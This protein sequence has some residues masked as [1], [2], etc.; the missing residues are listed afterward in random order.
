MALSECGSVS[1]ETTTV[2]QT[3]QIYP[4]PAQ[5]RITVTSEKNNPMSIAIVNMLGEVIIEKDNFES[6]TQIDI[7]HLPHSN[8]IIKIKNESRRFVFSKIN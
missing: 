7:S 3:I 2:N 8:Y 6:G 5:N 4:N 1:V